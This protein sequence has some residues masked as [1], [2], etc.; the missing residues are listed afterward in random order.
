MVL[1]ATLLL[2]LP[3]TA[4]GYLPPS[5]F[6]GCAIERTASP[7]AW[8][9]SSG[10]STATTA[11]VR[12]A[13]TTPQH[14]AYT[15]LRINKE[16]LPDETIRQMAASNQRVKELEEEYWKSLDA[17]E[18]AIERKC[19]SGLACLKVPGMLEK[20][21]EYYTSAAELRCVT[22]MVMATRN[23]AWGGWGEGLSG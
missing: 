4:S 17:D 11:V 1:V 5:F 22:V 2:S 14:R 12:S 3:A 6:R 9:P 18:I 7:S 15:R 8:P 16:D 19:A 10:G 23:R 13:G 21:A 20:A